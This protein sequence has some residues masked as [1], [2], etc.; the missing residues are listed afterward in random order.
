MNLRIVGKCKSAIDPE[1]YALLLYASSEVEGRPQDGHRER[2]THLPVRPS[3]SFTALSNPALAIYLPS[4]LKATWL[5]CFWCPV[6]LARGFFGFADGGLTGGHRKRV[7]S[8][9]PE[10]S[11]SGVRLV[12]A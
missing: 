7:W 3:H 12:K 8:S 5:T 11:C 1:P 4:G 6:N 2:Q 10:M 9:E